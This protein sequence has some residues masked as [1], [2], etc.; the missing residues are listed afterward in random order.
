MTNDV[1]EARAAL[2]DVERRRQ[3]VLDE[4]DV[5][6]WYWWILAAG[7]VG[8]GVLNDLAATAVSVGLTFAFSAMHGAI[9]PWV[10]SG[11]HRSRRLSVRR[12]L[13]D[14]HLPQYV[15]VTL[16]ALVAVTIATALVLDADGSRHPSII[17]SVFVAAII[18]IGGPRLTGALGRRTADRS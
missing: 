9:A 13:V 15:F 8:L 7:W 12:D 3:R 4:I 10:L 6:W 11:Q 2:L 16:V 17:A 18:V 1:T 14:R 5:P